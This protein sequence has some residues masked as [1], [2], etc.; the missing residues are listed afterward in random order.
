MG[1][2]KKLFSKECEEMKKYI[3]ENSKRARGHV[4]D[5]EGDF[6]NFKMG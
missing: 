4:S 2:E 3:D 5:L 6:I 1:R